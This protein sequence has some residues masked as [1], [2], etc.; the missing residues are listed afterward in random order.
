MESNLKQRIEAGRKTVSILRQIIDVYNKR[1]DILE[2]NESSLEADRL[3]CIERY[4]WEEFD[5]NDKLN[6]RYLIREEGKKALLDE[7]NSNSENQ[8]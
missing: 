4:L 1:L 7:L 3:F 2:Q 8:P 5:S 6:H